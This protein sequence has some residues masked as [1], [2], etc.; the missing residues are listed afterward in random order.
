MVQ[1]KKPILGAIISLATLLCLYSCTSYEQ[2][3]DYHGGIAVAKHSK[4][5][6][7]SYIDTR[8]KRINPRATF[9]GAKDFVGQY[10]LVQF[11]DYS[12]GFVDRNIQVQTKE[13]YNSLSQFSNGYAVFSLDGDNYGLLDEN[14]SI[15]LPPTYRS[16]SDFSDGYAK[17][18]DGNGYGYINT[19]LKE[20]IKCQYYSGRDF[21]DGIAIVKKDSDT[22]GIIDKQGKYT[23]IEGQY[24]TIGPFIEGM[25]KVETMDQWDKTVY[26]YIN[27]EGSL[28]VPCKFDEG[29][30]FSEGLVA[31]RER[32]GG[33][34]YYN[35][36][37]ELVIYGN[38]EKAS[39]FQNGKAL[40]S[41]DGFDFYINK[42]GEE[43]ET[44]SMSLIGRWK[45]RNREYGVYTIKFSG[46]S[47]EYWYPD[48]L[49]ATG[50]YSING[51]TITL[52]SKNGTTYT[53]SA[54]VNN[55][56]LIMGNAIYYKE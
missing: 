28:I 35:K 46:N 55:R 25:A 38:F 12:Y 18:K 48:R 16:I 5:W 20:V 17:V 30:D 47:F 37:G 51:T 40:V 43:E 19:D 4:K 26:G 21:S 7:F 11:E 34:R 2:Y 54:D 32:W 24:K 22:F 36:K 49:H 8:G 33:W 3:G 45:H 39:N 52:V 23:P 44:T 27:K 56:T 53:L 6:L 10:A 1:Y 41:K 29:L 13:K 9:H 42:K 14:C 15:A 31:V 50:S